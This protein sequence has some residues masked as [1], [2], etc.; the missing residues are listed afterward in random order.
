MNGRPVD[1][2]GERVLV[3]GGA[4][5][6]GSHVV[7]RLLA[8][9]ARV[10]VLDDL[11]TGRRENLARDAAVRFVEGDAAD[12]AVVRRAIEGC[13]RVVHLAA[14][15][16]V[17][18]SVEDPLG[19]HQA[20]LIATLQVLQAAREVSVARLVYAS[21]AAVYGDDR[22]PPV[23]EAGVLDP[24]TPYAADKLAGEH[25]LGFYRRTFGV[26]AVALRFFNV[27][28]PR[29]LADSPYSGVISLFADR[30][31]QGTPLKVYGDGR[32]TRDF[33]AVDDVVDAVVGCLTLERA[34]DPW[35]L[36]VGTGVATSVLELIAAVERVA[37]RRAQTTFEP[38][39]PGEVRDS[40]ADVARLRAALG[41]WAP[42]TL[43]VGL[44][45][46]LDT[47]GEGRAR[48]RMG[49]AP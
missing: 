33:V 8:Q 49:V 24:Q 37:G 6:I 47:V 12:G 9:G 29:Q 20:N 30:V 18:R 27:Y 2:S 1:L 40:R 19:T 16:S 3:T 45:R 41:E 10:T 48:D 7:D 28:G 42:R 23:A 15:A 32:Q 4:G 11:S 5:F 31:V 43:D 14:V 25:H 38:A 44:R 13:T 17:Q 26:P 46:L 36:N 21:S 22:P 35:V 34:P 39:R